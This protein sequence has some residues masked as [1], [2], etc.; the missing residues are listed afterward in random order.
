MN[1]VAS[2]QARMGSSRLPGK[3]LKEICGKPMLLWQIERL[4]KSRLLDDIIVATSIEKQDDIIE[5]FCRQHKVTC[6]RGSENDVL[7]RIASLIRHYNI[8]IH[9]E[10]YGDSPLID[11]QIVDE[12]VGYYLKNQN[13]IDYVSNSIKTTYPPGQEVVVYSGKILDDIEITLAISDPL[14]EHVG[15]NITRFPNKY[16]IVSLEAPMHFF[17]P[18]IYLEVDTIEDFAFISEVI[19]YFYDNNIES[20]SLS[21]MLAFLNVFPDLAMQNS[22]VPRRWK[23]LRKQNDFMES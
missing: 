22:M 16:R 19:R 10:C 6:F 15:Y 18:N 4:R 17:K 23:N 8:D 21:Q 7:N 12:F 11:P 1:I 20:P 9:V 5:E 14:R 13:I 3:V 2:I